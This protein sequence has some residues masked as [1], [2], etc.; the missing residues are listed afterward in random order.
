[1]SNFI[2]KTRQYFKEKFHEIHKWN[3]RDKIIAILAIGIL[4]RV[5][6]MPFFA[7]VDIMSTYKRAFTIA[8]EGKNIFSYSQE[9]PHIVEAITL[10]IYDIF[11]DAKNL[12]PFIP[13]KINSSIQINL[14]IFKLP[15]LLFDLT[16]LWILHK[17]TKKNKLQWKIL[18]FYFLNPLLIFAVYIFGRYE[19]IPITFALLSLLLLKKNRNFLSALSFGIAITTRSSFLIAWPIY[20]LTVGKKVKDKV[21]MAVLSILPYILTLIYKN[22]YIY[23]NAAGTDQPVIANAEVRWLMNGGHSNYMFGGEFGLYFAH[24]KIYPFIFFYAILLYLAFVTWQKKKQDWKVTSNFIAISFALFFATSFYHPQY[25]AWVV[26]FVALGLSKKNWR[27]ILTATTGIVL[28]FPILLLTWARSIL[29]GVAAPLSSTLAA[30][31]LNKEISVYYD[32]F[33]LADIARSV[34]SAMFCILIFILIPNLSKILNSK[35]GNDK[36][37]IKK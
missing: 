2:K 27:H 22:I 8:F 37:K 29:F 10:R 14:F 34:I 18:A 1:M 15:Y 23:N 7:H 35:I 6:C 33:K 25:L 11:L 19:T 17:L 4:I 5:L 20:V 36:V 32:A 31:D 26:P 28:A 16:A 13:S 21:A 9:I 24:A 30:I 12:Q 3:N